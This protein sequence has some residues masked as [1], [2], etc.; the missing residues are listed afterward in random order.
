MEYPNF[1]FSK[2][3]ARICFE[4]SVD[5]SRMAPTKCVKSGVLPLFL[6]NYG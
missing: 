5:A 1:D 2:N 6:W 3:K 4:F